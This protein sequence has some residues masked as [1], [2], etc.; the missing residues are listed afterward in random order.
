M[1]PGNNNIHQTK[2]QINP[3]NIH[4]PLDGQPTLF[5]ETATSNKDIA[6]TPLVTETEMEVDDSKQNKALIPLETGSGNHEDELDM[7]GNPASIVNQVISDSTGDDNLLSYVDSL[8]LTSGTNSDTGF[9]FSPDDFDCSPSQWIT[10]VVPLTVE[11]VSP[12]EVPLQGGN[13][14]CFTFNQTLPSNVQSGTATF[15]PWG[16]VDVKRCG[17]DSL[18]GKRIPSAQKSGRVTAILKSEFG[19]PLGEI[20]VLYVDEEKAIVQR[21]VNEPRLQ[22]KL[23]REL[24]SRAKTASE[25]ETQGSEN[26]DFTNPVQVLCLLIY[27]AAESGAQQF[28]AMIFNSSAGRIVFDAYKDRPLLPEVIAKSHGNEETSRYLEDI[29]LRHWTLLDIRGVS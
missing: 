18:V 22:S 16:N 13:L 1:N 23:L 2:E 4:V 6:Q 12:N 11:S 9:G 15:G 26:L 14:C 7:C 19:I 3:M 5:H 28:I 10:E 8:E 27:A 24:E 25:G 21:V 29:T 17:D 20:D